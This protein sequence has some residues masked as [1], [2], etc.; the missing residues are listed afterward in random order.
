MEV[1][2][3]AASYG[4]ELEFMVQGED[5]QEA[6]SAIHELISNGFYE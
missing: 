5:E 4:T 1:L 6:W 3:L 2:L